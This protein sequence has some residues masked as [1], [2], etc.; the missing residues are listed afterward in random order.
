MPRCGG[1]KSG[2]GREWDD[3]LVRSGGVYVALLDLTSPR[4]GKVCEWVGVGSE[5]GNASC[6]LPRVPCLTP[7]SLVLVPFRHVSSAPV[8]PAQ[9]TTS[10]T[11]FACKR[12]PHPHVDAAEG[13]NWRWRRR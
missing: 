13:L 3:A 2:A 9:L 8:L 7:L 11:L 6:T 1:V 10:D 4:L 5:R 12:N